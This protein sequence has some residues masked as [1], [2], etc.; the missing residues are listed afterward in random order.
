MAIY[1]FFSTITAFPMKV[2]AFY[3]QFKKPTAVILHDKA[4]RQ[5]F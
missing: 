1:Y 5:A 4:R 3:P 2:V